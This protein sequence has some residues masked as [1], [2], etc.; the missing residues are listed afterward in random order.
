[1]P[2]VTVALDAMG[3]DRAPAEIVAGAVAAARPGELEVVLVGREPAI[4]TALEGDPPPGVSIRHSDAAIDFDEE[5]ASAVRAKP[6]ASLVVAAAGVRDGWAQA[7]VSAGSTGA[8]LAAS[9]FAMRRIPGVIRPGL[10]TV[11]PGASGPITLI[12]SGANADCKPEMLV[13]FAHMGACF[14]EDVLGVRE[15][16]VGLL[17][18]GEERGKGNELARDAQVLLAAEP[19]LRFIGNIEGRDL[20]GDRVDVVVTDGFTGNVALKTVEGTAREVFKLF[21]SAADSSWRARIGGL[22]LRPAVRTLGVHMDPETYGGGFL[23]GLQG[24][25]VVAH[26]S[27]SRTAIANAVRMAADGVSHGVCT[28][29]AARVGRTA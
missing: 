15:P 3:G 2:P 4:R 24:I 27:S 25:A 7:A 14:G 11:L 21:R 23:L 17:T 18:I 28:H 1:M 22:L 9:L 16:R 26:G 6:D 8:M 13:Q 29:V 20:L 19:D 5:A 12:D 10:A